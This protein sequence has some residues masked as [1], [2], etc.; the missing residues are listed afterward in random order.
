MKLSEEQKLSLHYSAVS[1]VIGSAM[2]DISDVELRKEFLL[3]AVEDLEHYVD[4][5][6]TE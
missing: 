2:R 1:V 4:Q 3:W 6:A 5:L